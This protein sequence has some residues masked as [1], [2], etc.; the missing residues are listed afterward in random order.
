M[1]M[2]ECMK[3]QT[4]LKHVNVN[5]NRFLQGQWSFQVF[6]FAIKLIKWSAMIK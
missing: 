2:Y 3:E 5:C 4:K 1:A 6:V